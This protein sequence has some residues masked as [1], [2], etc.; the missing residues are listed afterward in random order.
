MQTLAH[1]FAYRS[2]TRALRAGGL[3]SLLALAALA[4]SAYAA[5]AHADIAIGHVLPLSGGEV[6]AGLELS[7]GAQ[8]YIDKV[9]AEGGIAGHRIVYLM[10]DNENQP[11]LTLSQSAE[12]IKKHKVVGFLPNPEA[13]QVKSLVSSGLLWQSGTVIVSVRNSLPNSPSLVNVAE[14]TTRDAGL[15]EITPPLDYYA[16]LIEEFR[17]N[18]AKYGP[19][20]AAFSSAGLQGYMAAKVMVNAVRMLSENPASDAQVHAE[21]RE[22][23]QR[24]IPDLA[25]KLIISNAPR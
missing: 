23:M 15:I 1:A 16:P 7:Q 22:A 13:A 25:S 4:F 2:S 18:L 8:A 19:P 11:A 12:L 10:R 6:S 24:M 20:D 3:A 14:G 9:N 17:A 5:P 21:Y